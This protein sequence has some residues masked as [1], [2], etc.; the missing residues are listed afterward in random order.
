MNPHLIYYPV[1]AMII[2]TF[3]VL[4]RLFILRVKSLREGSV[5]IRYFKTYDLP[6]TLPVLQTQ[7][8]RNFTNLFEV[9]TLFYV[10]CAFILVMNQVDQVF[11][12]LAWTYVAVRAFHSFIHIT[13]NKIN[14]RMISYTLSW[15]VLLVMAIRLALLLY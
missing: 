6:A 15:I 14:P 10:V 13:S 3:S 8:A 4:I 5:D 9:P 12:I 2:L 11:L 1:L 7:A